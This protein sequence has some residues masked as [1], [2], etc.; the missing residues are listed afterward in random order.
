MADNPSPTQ[1]VERHWTITEPQPGAL[2][3]ATGPRPPRDA[4]SGQR[5]VRV[6]SVED[7]QRL[8]QE[9]EEQ[10]DAEVDARVSAQGEAAT[11]KSRL[12]VE[13]EKREEVERER[14][15]GG[16][17][18]TL[19]EEFDAVHPGSVPDCDGCKVMAKLRRMRKAADA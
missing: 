6:L 16:E 5:Q 2:L 12:R 7:H 17:L 3:V 13:A 15:S 8:L 11:L 9:V 19:I 14:L 1:E 10:R 18:D 4:E